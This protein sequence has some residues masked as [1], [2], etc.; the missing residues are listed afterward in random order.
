MSNV[1]RVVPRIQK[2]DLEETTTC[3]CRILEWEKEEIRYHDIFYCPAHSGID[4]MRDLLQKVE[5]A[6]YR[7]K[8]N[9]DAI[10]R[11]DLNKLHTKCVRIRNEFA[12]PIR[13][14]K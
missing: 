10:G 14:L 12:K 1:G 6:L 7:I 9:P 8:D 13:P 11:V 4:K 5:D 3:G 2:T